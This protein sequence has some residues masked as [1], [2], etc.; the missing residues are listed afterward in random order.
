MKT[1]STHHWQEQ[2]IDHECNRPQHMIH[3]GS[4]PVEVCWLHRSDHLKGLSR[5]LSCNPFQTHHPELDDYNRRLNR[6]LQSWCL[7]QN[8]QAYA[9]LKHGFVDAVEIHE[10]SIWTDSWGWYV[11]QAS[12]IEA[13]WRDWLSLETRITR[14]R[15]GQGWV[16]HPRSWWVWMDEKSRPEREWRP[17][18][19][20]S[21]MDHQSRSKLRK[22]HLERGSYNPDRRYER[23]LLDRDAFEIL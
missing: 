7:F 2:T 18:T 12:P 9:I 16:S 17:L 3:K 4:H 8:D 1:I 6:S 21:Q 22:K 15:K 23:Y 19:L 5:S 20:V 14:P 11:W 13:S 10:S